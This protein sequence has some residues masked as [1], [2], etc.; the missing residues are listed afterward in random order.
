MVAPGV[1]YPSYLILAGGKK[2]GGRVYL[3]HDLIIVLHVLIQRIIGKVHIVFPVNIYT[4][5]FGIYGFKVA[6]EAMEFLVAVVHNGAKI[7]SLA[8]MV[9]QRYNK[10]KVAGICSETDYGPQ[11]LKLYRIIGVALLSET[12]YDCETQ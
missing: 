1:I 6:V 12:V 8:G 10:N 9:D 3:L 11:I 7:L 2:I 5:A 4:V